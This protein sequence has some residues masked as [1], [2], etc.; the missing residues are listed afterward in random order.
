[1]S[2]ALPRLDANAAAATRMAVAAGMNGVDPTLRGIALRK[3][4]SAVRRGTL[5]P[6]TVDEAVQRGDQ[7]LASLFPVDQLPPVPSLSAEAASVASKGSNL[8]ECMVQSRW[9]IELALR[10]RCAPDGLL[11][12][13]ASPHEAPSRTANLL[14]QTWNNLLESYRPDW[15][16]ERVGGERS[17]L[18]ALPM[19][20]CDTDYY[21]CHSNGRA[22]VHIEAFGI[23]RLIVPTDQDDSPALIYALKI[24][25]KASVYPIAAFDLVDGR[26]AYIEYATHEFHHDLFQHLTWPEG[27]SEPVADLEA[28]AA[29]VEDFGYDAQDAATYAEA[30]IAEAVFQRRMDQVSSQEQAERILSKSDS[31]VASVAKTLLGLAEQLDKLHKGKRRDWLA[32]E[33]PTVG[34]PAHMAGSYEDDPLL[35]ALMDSIDMDCQEHA[36]SLRLHRDTHSMPEVDRQMARLVAEML[37]AEYAY[38]LVFEAI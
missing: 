26:S 25:D 22:L 30:A 1:M 3:I 38:A 18:Q 5:S 32:W 11:E 6:S 16:P 24:L 12:A 23:S 35:G 21:D 37:V 4:R 33:I 8:S 13:L 10:R 34:L 27:A 15:L 29:L 7:G 2:L 28:V 31:K 9:F 19:A 36:P 14:I 17:G 20:F